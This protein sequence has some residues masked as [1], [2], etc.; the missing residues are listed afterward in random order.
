MNPY[1]ARIE[2]MGMIPDFLLM[3]FLQACTAFYDDFALGFIIRLIQ[4]FS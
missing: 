2:T 4:L 3:I 1:F